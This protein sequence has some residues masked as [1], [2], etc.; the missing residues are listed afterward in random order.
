MGLLREGIN[1]V[2]GTTSINAAPMGV[3]FR[4]GRY[5]LVAYL[6]S[7]TAENIRNQGYLVANIVHD[8]VIYVMTAFDDLPEE[9]FVAEKIDGMNVHRLDCAEAWVAMKAN[10]SRETS[11][12]LI[13]SLRPLYQEVMCD[14]VFPV[15][16]G[17]C[18]V[19]EATVHATRLIRTKDPVLKDLIDHHILLAKRCGGKREFEA[20]ELLLDYIERHS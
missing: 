16:R 9:A 17:F 20:I 1:E 2:I 11:E 18:N 4:N 13:V 5:S 7:H 6:G 12:A 8:P 15:N 19:I 3:I 10:V 14:L